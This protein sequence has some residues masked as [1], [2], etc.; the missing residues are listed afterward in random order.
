M[1]RPKSNGKLICLFTGLV[2]LG[3]TILNGP[4]RAAEISPAGA[5]NLK[6]MI[7][8]DLVTFK[9]IQAASKRSFITEGD[10]LVEPKDSYYA[11][12]LPYLKIIDAAGSS[13][14]IGKPVLNITPG[15]DAR[16]WKMS[17]ALPPTIK[18]FDAKAVQA[19]Q[20]NIGQQKAS[21]VWSR[22]AVGF[23]QLDATYED[24]AYSDTVQK[25]RMNSPEIKV[26][27]NLKKDKNGNFSGPV[28]ATINDWSMT[29]P[30]ASTSAGK[31][32]FNATVQNFNAKF[33]QSFAQQLSA[34]GETGFK[35]GSEKQTPQQSIALF[36]LVADLVGKSAEGFGGKLSIDNFKSSNLFNG[37]KSDLS[38]NDMNFT[39]GL[40]GFKENLVK[41][42]LDL[43]YKGLKQ[44][45]ADT[46]TQELVPSDGVFKMTFNNIP[47]NELVT[48]GRKNIMSRSTKNPMANL[49]LMTMLPQLL[50]T[51]N[52]NLSFNADTDAP[53]FNVHSDGVM[54]AN[55]NAAKGYTQDVNGEI[56][57][58]DTVIAKLNDKMKDPQFSAKA[59]LGQALG[60]LSVLQLAGQQ[61]PGGGDVRTY[62]LVTGTDGKT[63]LNGADITLLMA[64]AK[65]GSIK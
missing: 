55:L 48:L 37:K 18:F 24:I 29:A 22:D 11:V 51:A 45:L 9:N 44:N 16:E 30:G 53:S 46:G 54:K 58:L 42:D 32:A 50:T 61:K 39:Y 21:G 19:G 14:D 36:N 3:L 33:A 47:Y 28:N 20:L 65:M 43:D 62:K 40:N 1:P 57:G 59:Q 64:A 31:I 17:F 63:L 27:Y 60:F 25:M 26:I 35:M 23:T 4:A 56:K 5:Q 49:E 7:Q 10:V 34:L 41:L 52:S 13:T 6:A 15:A 12:T 2:V 38:F 8:S